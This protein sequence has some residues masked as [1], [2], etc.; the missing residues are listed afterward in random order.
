MGD[1][2]VHRED[3]IKMRLEEKAAFMSHDMGTTGG[4]L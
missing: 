1:E 3:N 2:D 4:L